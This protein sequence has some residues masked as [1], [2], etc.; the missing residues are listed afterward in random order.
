M[1]KHLIYKHTFPNDKVY[2]GQCVGNT[3][4]DA[5]KR[6]GK[7]GNSYKKQLVYRAIKKYGWDSIRH[8]I[9]E[10]VNSQEDADKQEIY[11]IALY[12]STDKLK[13]YNIQLGGN[14]NKKGKYEGNAKER[15]RCAVRNYYNKHSEE[16]KGYIRRYCKE[17]IDK[18]MEYMRNYNEKKTPEMKQIDRER[19]KQYGRTHKEKIKQYRESH[20]EELKQKRQ[21]KYKEFVKEHGMSPN[22]WKRLMGC[23]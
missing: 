3:I 2:I 20:R 5:E 16:R 15:G 1:G 22:K 13:G 19:S 18:I 12:D 4:E 14:K 6:W 9:L 8:E 11:Y 23:D 7:D 21:Q 17:N 10:V